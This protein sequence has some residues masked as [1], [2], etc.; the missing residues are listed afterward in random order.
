MQK[1][2]GRTLQQ[3]HLSEIANTTKIARKVLIATNKRAKNIKKRLP[4]STSI[5]FS[6]IIFYNNN[7]NYDQLLVTTA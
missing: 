5:H 1:I 4:F 3:Y 2:A 7:S 6:R